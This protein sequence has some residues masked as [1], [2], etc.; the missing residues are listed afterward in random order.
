MNG[1]PSLFEMDHNY[2]TPVIVEW[3]Q[4]H[5]DK[6]F[7]NVGY[8]LEI[9]NRGFIPEYKYTYPVCCRSVINTLYT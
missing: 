4:Y 5:P 7:N 1:N 2:N 9:G 8:I 6:M 3:K